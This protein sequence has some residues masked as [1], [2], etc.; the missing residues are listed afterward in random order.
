MADGSSTFTVAIT[1]TEENPAF[2]GNLVKEGTGTITLAGINTYSG[3]TT[4]S[5]GA[6]EIAA[7]GSLRFRPTTNGTTN[8]VSGPAPRRCP[9]SAP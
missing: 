8:A 7:T 2:V 9:S 5:D 6:L 4:V 3:N 1:N